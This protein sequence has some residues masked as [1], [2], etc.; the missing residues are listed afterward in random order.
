MKVLTPPDA[1][2]TLK[3]AKAL[4]AHHNSLEAA[5]KPAEEIVY[6]IIT[7]EEPPLKTRDYTPRII[8]IPHKFGK[9]RT[10]SILFISKDP[11]LYYRDQFQAPDCDTE[12]LFKGVLGL[13]KFESRMHNK[14]YANTV[15][16]E[17]DVVMADFRLH[18]KLAPILGP[19]FYEKNRKVPFMIQTNTP[20]E[21]EKM[22]ILRKKQRVAKKEDETIDTVDT[23]YVYRQV[24]TI[25]RNT[26]VVLSS[27]G[28]TM[29]VKVGTLGMAPEQIVENVDTVIDFLT[30]SQFKPAGGA[31]VG[32]PGLSKNPIKRVCIKTSNS[33]SLP[34]GLEKLNQSALEQI[35]KN[36]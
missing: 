5:K 8:K 20:E 12:D 1:E 21:L 4:Q 22:K 10:H 17:Y 2:L 28:N 19:K 9:I 32:W 29:S 27:S 24:K 34:V 33:S 11:V 3:S 26:S 30:N 35:H 23:A 36:Y 13:K 31:V 6:L 7:S 25:L 15:F 16:N 14:R 18:H